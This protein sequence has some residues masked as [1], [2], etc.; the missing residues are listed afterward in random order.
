MAAALVG[1]IS[2]LTRRFSKRQ[3][4]KKQRQEEYTEN[5]ESLKNENAKRVRQLSDA[6]V[7]GYERYASVVGLTGNAAG[8]GVAD[9]VNRLDMAEAPVH[10]SCGGSG[11]GITRRMLPS[12][13][14]VVSVAPNEPVRGRRSH[15]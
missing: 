14:D 1:C 3:R 11:N 12:Y 15:R 10:T 7:V 2:I 5:F 6:G 13:E 8:A 4:E 9:G